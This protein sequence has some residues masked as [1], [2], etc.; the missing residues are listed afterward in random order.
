M[1]IVHIIFY[2]V[3]CTSWYTVAEELPEYGIYKLIAISDG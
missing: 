1:K 3:A 2:V